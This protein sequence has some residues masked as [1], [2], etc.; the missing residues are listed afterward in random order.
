MRIRRTSP[1]LGGRRGDERNRHVRRVGSWQSHVPTWLGT[2]LQ[3]E[4]RVRTV[5]GTKGKENTEKG[6]EPF[7]GSL[8]TGV[9]SECRGE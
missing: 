3:D 6:R 1:D 4:P 7:N 2:T 5:E 9:G 8:E